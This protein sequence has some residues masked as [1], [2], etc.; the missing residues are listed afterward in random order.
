MNRGPKLLGVPESE[1]KKL[2]ARIEYATSEKL[3]N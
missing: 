2:Y 3:K 1:A